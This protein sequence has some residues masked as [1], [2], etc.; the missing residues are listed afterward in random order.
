MH[1]GH[2][3]DAL[4]AVDPDVRV[5]RPGGNVPSIRID[6]QW[7]LET[8]SKDT[9]VAESHVEYCDTEVAANRLLGQLVAAGHYLVGLS[10]VPVL[11]L[12]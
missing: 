6:A 3:L 4:K 7:R 12:G 2:L 8:R 9:D 5:V 10:R 1:V 11:I